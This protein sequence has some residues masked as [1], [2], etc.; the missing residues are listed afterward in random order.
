M[1]LDPTDWTS[2][3]IFD[4]SG[5]VRM[6]LAIRFD[7]RVASTAE[8]EA[9]CWSSLAAM[10]VPEHAEQQGSVRSVVARNVFATVLWVCK[11]EHA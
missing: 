7:G 8:A 3:E 2:C 4:A 10:T 1:S 5:L 6:P 11:P 9:E